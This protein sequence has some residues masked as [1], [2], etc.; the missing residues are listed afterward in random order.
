MSIAAVVQPG[1]LLYWQY[2]IPLPGAHT[3]L[4]THWV[5]VWGAVVDAEQLLI[6]SVRKRR[7]GDNRH[8]ILITD[9]E[10]RKNKKEKEAEA[11]WVFQ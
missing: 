8:I 6:I 1:P 11:L 5:E 10:K 3:H 2:T 9:R 4:F 7:E